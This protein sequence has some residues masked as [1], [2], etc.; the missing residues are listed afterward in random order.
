[1][2]SRQAP[3]N[4]SG[5]VADHVTSRWWPLAA[6]TV[7][8]VALAL[9]GVLPRWP[10]LPHLVALPPVDLF[11]D[12]RVLLTRATSVPAFALLLALVFGVRVLVMSLL[13]GGLTRDRL[14]FGAVFYGIVFL[15][16]L[17]AAQFGYMAFAVLYSRL[18]WPA[19]A[20]VTVLA[21]LAGPMPWQ[22]STRL[23]TALYRTWRG[24]L[25]VGIMLPYAAVIVLLSVVTHVWPGSEVAL[26]PISALATGVTIG[27]LSRPPRPGALPRLVVAGV[28]FAVAS[29]VFVTTRDVQAPPPPQPREGSMMVMSGIN[30]SS[31]NG[32]VFFT[33]PQDYGLTCEQLFYYSYAGPGDGQPRGDARC[34]IRTGAPFEPEH[35]R[36]PMAEQVAVFSEQVRGLPRPL[37]VMVHS[38]S[39]WVAWKAVSS[40][41]APEV[42]VLI[43][44]G[45]FRESIQGYLAP[46]ERGPGRVASD[47]LR[48]LLPVGTLFGLHL[49]LDSP[50]PR[51][52]L[53]DPDAPEQIFARPLPPGVRVISVTSATDLPLMPGGWRLPVERNACP[54]REAHPYLPGSNGMLDE[55][56][57]FLRGAPPRSCPPWRDWGTAMTR[58]F[59]VPAAN[60]G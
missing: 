43:L 56:N 20:V 39:A 29:T 51:E 17:A 58:S 11:A 25:R 27:L 18:F 44:N 30:S 3:P 49:D 1:M 34:P 14:R 33:D 37:M 28:A 7:V 8:V 60:E 23:R 41:K 9:A 45:A 24:G 53:A 10:G 22:G 59:G 52:T 12:L 6:I 42:D 16:S 4:R 32:D 36:R 19:V 15:P 57:R 47:L 2:G 38:H 54:L 40:G 55:V 46:G 48:L 13:L 35:T 50:A 21:L 5:D 31:G 26:V